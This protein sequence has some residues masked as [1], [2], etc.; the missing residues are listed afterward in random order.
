MP[1]KTRKKEKDQWLI[2]KD[3]RE[4]LKEQFKLLKEKVILEIFSKKGENEPY[5]E[6]AIRFATDL[7]RLADKIE[8]RQNKIGDARA[9]KYDVTR[10]PTVLINPEQYHIRYSGAPAG[11]EGVSFLQAI[12][13]VSLR[14]S[15]LSK[16]SKEM[17]S[18]L[19]DKR[20]VQ[21]YITP[22]CPYCPGQVINAFKAAIERPHLI[23]S[24]CVDSTQNLDLAKKYNVGSVPQTVINEKTISL[25]FEPEERFISELISLQP[26]EVEIPAVKREMIET[27]LI[28]IGAGPA[29]LTAGIYA[30]RSGL[31]TI[32]LEKANVGGQVSITPVVENYPGFQN[33]PGKKLMAMIAAQARN[34]A[35]IRE[36]EEVREIKVGKLIEAITTRAHYTAKALLLATGAHYKKLDV[37]GEAKFY[38]HGVSY[39]ATCDG[40]L[41]KGKRV[42]V[43]GG[44]NTALTDALHL[45]NLGASVTIIHHRE[46]FRADKHLQESVNREGI[47][48]LW[49]SAVEEILGD[50]K[51]TAVKLKNTKNNKIQ[52][53]ETDGVFIAV[54]EQPNNQLALQIGLTLDESGFIKSD[55][56]GRTNIPRIYAAGDVTIG[57]RQIVTAVGEGAAAAQAIFEDI[58]HPYWHRKAK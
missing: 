46:E 26:A 11:E 3:S 45:K 54:G 33:I 23:S 29:G 35:D 5:N 1:G 41:F 4:Q 27:D 53:I 42:V 38:G 25:G 43:V 52:E 36:G 37:P 47:M 9:K 14:E 55:R 32:I 20:H 6:L 50:E 2:P 56:S 15:G 57:L 22:D 21:V 49:N 12:M 19:K 51:L 48:I 10:S 13:L 40:Y 30:K 31:N 17:L 8:L 16:T 7:S 58:S 39:C 34:Y 28:I 44:G 24:E 18:R